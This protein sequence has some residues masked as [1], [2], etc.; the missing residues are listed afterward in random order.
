MSMSAA[1]LQRH[2]PPAWR[3]MLAFLIVPGAAA[4]LMASLMPAYD[5]IRAPLERFW[6]SALAFAIF[7]A[8][9]TTVVL[10][11]PAYFLLRRHFNPKVI[12][13]SLTGALVAALPWLILSSLSNPDSAS[14][15]GRATV[16]NG[17]KT[18]YGWLTELAFVGQIAAFGAIGGALFWLIAGSGGRSTTVR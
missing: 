5:G 16:I 11:V 7:G 2:Y 13:C 18:A 9:P 10:G 3:I 17:S 14:I 6:R 12:N 4:L 15:D 8:Y 1:T